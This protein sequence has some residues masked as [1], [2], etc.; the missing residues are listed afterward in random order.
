MPVYKDNAVNR[1]L[2]RV[3]KEYGKIDRS[4]PPPP[5]PGPPPKKK[6]KF[7]KPPPPPPGPPPKK[8]KKFQK[9]P[10]KPP[11][12]VPRKKK[13]PQMKKVMPQKAVKIPPKKREVKVPIRKVVPKTELD[14][15][16]GLT[17]AEANKLSTLQ[18]FGMMPQE[19]RRQIL[20]PKKTGVK[21][22]DAYASM[23]K[24][25]TVELKAKGYSG[26]SPF[27]YEGRK[28]K[29]NKLQFRFS[30]THGDDNITNYDGKPQKNYYTPA[31]FDQMLKKG[32][33]ITTHQPHYKGDSTDDKFRIHHLNASSMSDANWEFS[34]N[35]A[36]YIGYYLN[37]NTKEHNKA[38]EA[39]ENDKDYVITL[40]IPIKNSLGVGRKDLVFTIKD[41]T[42][43]YS[44]ADAL[45]RRRRPYFDTNELKK[46]GKIN[47]TDLPLDGAVIIFP[48]EANNDVKTLG[49]GVELTTMKKIIP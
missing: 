15:R 45:G 16:T 35:L 25:K 27:I 17:K 2:G 31:K 43:N 49:K 14:K 21:V 40:K 9:P 42:V 19:I 5:P 33:V 13:K 48:T 24:G 22:G 3:G 32:L 4:K 26:N 37:N 1:R 6:K 8:K 7:Q 12:G 34:S 28:K 38:Y 36:Q 39:H 44:H 47:E 10:P 11:R 30:N 20:N 18:L 29:D 41:L 23:L 46:K